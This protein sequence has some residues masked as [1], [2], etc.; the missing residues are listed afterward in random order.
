MEFSSPLLLKEEISTSTASLKLYK[1]AEIAT[2]LGCSITRKSDEKLI[3]NITVRRPYSEAPCVFGDSTWYDAFLK[4]RRWTK[5]RKE[6]M[7]Q[8]QEDL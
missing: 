6:L 7:T 3:V 5:E 8:L 4:C 1:Q 2:S